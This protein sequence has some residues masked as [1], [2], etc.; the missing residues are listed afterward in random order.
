MFGS[1]PGHRVKC[2]WSRVCFWSGLSLTN[3]HLSCCSNFCYCYLLLLLLLLLRTLLNLN[4]VFNELFISMDL[5]GR[6]FFWGGSFTPFYGHCE[7]RIWPFIFIFFLLVLL[8]QNYS[9]F[10]LMLYRWILYCVQFPTYVINLL[11]GMKKQRFV[12]MFLEN[13]HHILK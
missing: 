5:V 10:A 6:C 3:K 2:V 4:S 13:V 12:E 9:S 1:L 8:I 11:P 7:L